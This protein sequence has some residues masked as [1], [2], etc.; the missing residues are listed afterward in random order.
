[1]NIYWGNSIFRLKRKRKRWSTVRKPRPTAS[2]LA[3]A[4]EGANGEGGSLWGNHGQNE[5][6]SPSTRLQNTVANMTYEE[7]LRVSMF[8]VDGRTYRVIFYR[9]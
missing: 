8:E 1:M 5:T 7:S 6:V 3:A 4:A 9:Q 2:Q